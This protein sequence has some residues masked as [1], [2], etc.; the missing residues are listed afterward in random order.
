[1]SKHI[2]SYTMSII[3]TLLV[4]C[5]NTI[6]LK[7]ND[8]TSAGISASS[9]DLDSSNVGALSGSVY[10]YTGPSDTAHNVINVDMGADYLAGNI[11]STRSILNLAGTAVCNSVFSDLVASNMHRDVA[12][13]QMTLTTE[14]S[15]LV[16]APGY[17]DIPDVTKDD[18]GYNGSSPVL[19]A[20]RPANTCGTTQATIAARIAD[21]EE[22]NGSCTN[23]ALTTK[24]TCEADSS[25]WTSTA[26][27][28]GANKGISGEGTWRLV[29][30]AAGGQEVWRDERTGLIWGDSAGSNTWCRASGNAQTLAQDG[31]GSGICD[32]A[33]PIGHGAQDIMPTSICAESGSLAPALGGEDWVTGVYDVSKGGMG[34]VATG[35]SP[36]VR[37]RL[38]TKYDWH[39]A[40]NNGIRFVLPNMDNAFWS[41]SVVSYNRDYAWNF[42]GYYG[43]IGA[44]G[45]NV[46]RAVRCVGR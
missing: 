15:T 43:S 19:K 9:L 35:S 32:P 1:M 17:R 28:I 22:V 26:T 29:T 30:R 41:A 13:A 8:V 21:C 45:R 33:D 4:G 2:K 46:N 14:I 10:T 7:D 5:E 23:G 3:L 25:T 40:D 38:P 36:S 16:Y 42:G 27:W 39:A 6:K 44:S 37:W 34:A 18:D 20:T 12:T 31:T 24:A 11:C